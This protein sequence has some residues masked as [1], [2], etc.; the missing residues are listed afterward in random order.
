MSQ[1]QFRP[2]TKPTQI[3]LGVAQHDQHG[4]D[5]DDTAEIR[6]GTYRRV[7]QRFMWR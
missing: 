4:T 1:H 6:I 2:T 5:D 3:R 7:Q